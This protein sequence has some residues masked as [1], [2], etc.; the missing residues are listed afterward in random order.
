MD[1]LNIL[2]VLLGA[3]LLTVGL[4]TFYIGYQ[5]FLELQ[6]MAGK[7]FLFAMLGALLLVVGL[8]CGYLAAKN[9]GIF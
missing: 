9:E 5:S 4:F 1:L 2:I 3:L 8:G 7:P 6:T